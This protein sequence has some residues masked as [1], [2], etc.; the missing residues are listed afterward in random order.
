NIGSDLIVSGTRTINQ[1]NLPLYVY[2]RDIVSV[3]LRRQF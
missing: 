1:S 2:D 3:R